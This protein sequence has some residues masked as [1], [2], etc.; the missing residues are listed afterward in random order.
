MISLV[1]CSSEGAQ[2]VRTVDVV[3]AGEAGQG[4]SVSSKNALTINA[5]SF[6]LNLTNKI[7]PEIQATITA[8]AARWSDVLLDD[9]TVNL[10]FDYRPLGSGVLASAG[11]IMVYNTFDDIRNLVVANDG[12][13]YNAREAALLPSHL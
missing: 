9:V 5:T 1:V 6:G 3:N 13:A 10:D 8:A 11:S 7:T 2:V 4:F 12:V